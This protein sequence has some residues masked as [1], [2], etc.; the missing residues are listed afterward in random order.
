MNPEL[1]LG[2]AQ[3]GSNYG[4][5][6][7]KGQV[8]QLEIS[9]IISNAESNKIKY[10]DTA[11]NYGDAEHRLGITNL[12][13]KNFKIIN[14]FS[15]NSKIKW[16][17]DIKKKWDANLEKSFQNLGVSEFDGFLIHNKNDVLREDS[18]LLIE[19]LENLKEN[20]IIK[21]IGISIYDE[22]DIKEI[23]LEK[24]DLIQLPLSIYDQRF[25]R[26]RIIDK[27]HSLGK[28]IHL[29]SIFLQGI[30]LQEPKSWPKFFSNQFK[31]HHQ[32]TYDMLKDKEFTI[33]ELALGFAFSCKKV[34]A[35]LVG[36]TDN[37]ELERILEVLNSIKKNNKNYLDESL[38]VNWDKSSEIDPRYWPNV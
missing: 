23:P 26:N 7:K 12:S 27:L 29:R 9:K 20:S 25:L 30:I 35:V 38:I 1:C 15:D 28:K 2:T 19:W 22:K 33:L 16:D 11:Q 32:K 18:H 4:I 24:F 3:F 13:K 36:I 6:N 14:K 17:K 5:T 21:R 37:N 8:K 31:N 34:E 10:L